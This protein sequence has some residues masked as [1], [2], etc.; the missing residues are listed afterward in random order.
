VPVGAADLAFAESGRVRIEVAFG[1]DPRP[2][3]GGVEQR[4]RPR[5]RAA[6]HE[7]R[8]EGVPRQAAR[9]DDADAGHDRAPHA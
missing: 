1:S 4:D 8:P 5:R 3:P 2:Q 7:L 9:G 6:C